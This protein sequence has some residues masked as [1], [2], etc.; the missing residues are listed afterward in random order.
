M[1]SI[2]TDSDIYPEFEDLWK[3]LDSLVDET[4]VWDSD[5]PDIL[6]FAVFGFR[7]HQKAE[8]WMEGHLRIA[9]LY[10]KGLFEMDTP[11]EEME[12]SLIALGT[13]LGLFSSGRIDERLYRIG[14]I[15]IPGFLMAKQ[16]D[17]G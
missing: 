2:M 6:E 17:K 13:L 7:R 15:L 1:N 12:F 14:Y 16:A 4:G 9:A 3:N 8:E 5:K 10:A 11:D